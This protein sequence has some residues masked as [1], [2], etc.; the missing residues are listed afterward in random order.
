M[1]YTATSFAEPLRRVFAELYRPNKELTIDF[2]PESKYFVESIEYKS[3]ITPWFE[4]ALYRPFVTLI[5]LIARQVRRMQSGSVHA[6][7]VYVTAILVILLL[8]A[9]WL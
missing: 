9:R 4:K 5:R 8:L 2:H 6:Y 1:E 7:L 3:E